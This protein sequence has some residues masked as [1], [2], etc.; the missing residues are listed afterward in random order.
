MVLCKFGCI[1]AVW[2]ACLFC[3][4]ATGRGD[5]PKTE[6]SR[7]TKSNAPDEPVW[8]T[9]SHVSGRVIDPEGKPCVGAQVVLVGKE[10][11]F[12]LPDSG[13]WHVLGNTAKRL[14]QA[15]TDEEGRFTLRT[16]DTPAN[17]IA[18]ISRE[19]RLWVVPRKA[20]ASADDVTITLPKPGS[21]TVHVDLPGK[22][23]KQDMYIELRTFDGVDWEPDLVSANFAVDNPGKRTYSELPPAH[24]TVERTAYTSLGPGRGKLMTPCERQLVLVESGKQASVRFKHDVGPSIEGHV[25]GLEGIDLTYATI[26]IRYLGP[27]ERRGHHAEGRVRLYTTFEAIPIKADGHFL[28]DPVPPGKYS[29]D[30]SAERASTPSAASDGTITRFRGEA[31]FTIPE[32]GGD[33]H[34]EIVAVPY[35]EKPSTRTRGPRSPRA[36]EKSN[37]ARLETTK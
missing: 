29:I 21:L 31:K 28:S 4:A 12:V 34:I 15:T 30:L 26:C 33:Q 11:I 24:Y 14:P 18:V 16:G 32:N 9:F 10:R 35:K 2:I 17:R 23:A 27:V 22:P 13:Q 20:F 37:D 7:G 36:A 3:L 25:S 8:P 19:V 5:D 6:P 1:A